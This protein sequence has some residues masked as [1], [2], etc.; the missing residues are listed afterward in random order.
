MPIPTA[1]EAIRTA[2]AQTVEHVRVPIYQGYLWKKGWN[3]TNWKRRFF[4]LRSNI[5]FYYAK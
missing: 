3:K 2:A 5:L 4:V 1:P